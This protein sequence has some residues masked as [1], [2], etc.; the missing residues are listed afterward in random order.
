MWNKEISPFF[1]LILLFTIIPLCT[2]AYNPAQTPNRPPLCDILYSPDGVF[3]AAL[4]S[5]YL[6]LLYGETMKPVLRI[7]NYYQFP[8]LQKKITFSPDSSLIAISGG[9]GIELWDVTSKTLVASIPVEI[10]IAPAFSPDGRYLAYA[11]GD[12]IFLWDIMRKKVT[13]ELAGD[14]EPPLPGFSEQ[15][16]NAIAFQPNG[17][18]LAVGSLRRTIALWDIETGKIQSHLKMETEDEYPK[19]IRFNNDG[20]Q[21][22][23]LFRKSV[24]L[25]DMDKEGLHTIKGFN[26]CYD[27][28]FTRDNK[29]LLITAGDRI[30]AVDLVNFRSNII[31]TTVGLPPPYFGGKTLE[32]LTIHPNGLEFA[33][34]LNISG[35]VI[36]DAK[37]LLMLKLFYNWGMQSIITRPQ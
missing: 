10:F 28:G 21:M 2:Y 33:T 32:R 19:A 25:W 18:V 24:K 12:S 6:E 13:A 29:Y 15:Y 3:L 36:W 1:I 23:V 5:S 30:L 34:S 8:G 20:S 14:I 4:N 35:I 22:A 16:I 17:R 11:V 37:E 7:D 27:A 26:T 31:A 9:K